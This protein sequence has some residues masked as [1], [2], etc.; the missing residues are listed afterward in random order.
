MMGL[1]TRSLRHRPTGA[2]ATFV[3]VLLGTALMASFATLVESALRAADED[4]ELLILMGAVVGGWAALIVAFSAAS[5]VGIVAEQRSAEASLLRAVGATPRQARAL[6]VG[7]A[8]VLALVAAGAGALVASAGGPALFAALRRGGLITPASS[9]AGGPASLAVAAGVVVLVSLLAAAGSSGRA[10]RGPAALARR[11]AQA[12]SWRM[13]RWRLIVGAV[14]VAGGVASAIVTLTVT[15]KAD[16]AYPAMQTSGSASIVVGVG[17]A[18]LA[19]VLARRLLAPA[20]PLLLRLDDGTPGRFAGVG[21]LVAHDI[22]RR[23]QLLAGMLAPVIVLVSTAVGTM[24]MVGIDSR[25]LAAAGDPEQ[26]G[27]TITMLNS[28]IIGMVSLFAAIMVVNATVA[29]VKHRRAELTRLWRLGATAGQLRATVVLEA[30]LVS[31]VGILL[32]LLGSTATAVPY[33]IVRHEGMVPDGQLWVPPLVA[34]VAVAL[35]VGTAGAAA[36]V[37]QRSER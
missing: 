1:A 17:L 21:Q 12:S 22:T 30:A 9:Y 16:N 27:G 35:A 28:V 23:P 31:A 11:A 18:A 5:T 10:T 19:P 6:I 20:R 25:T 33:A 2:I 37:R 15:G 29:V 3:T 32:G 4:R 24:L 14:L 36:G 8:L 26:V 7:E 34:A 13:P